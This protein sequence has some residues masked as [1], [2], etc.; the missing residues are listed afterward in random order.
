[1][2]LIDVL[3]YRMQKYGKNARCKTFHLFCL[4][5]LGSCAEIYDTCPLSLCS[6]V[7]WALQKHLLFAFVGMRHAMSAKK[8]YLRR[9]N[10]EY[11]YKQ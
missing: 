5:I 3:V 1:M 9:G 8:R 4:L 7:I 10:K 11:S 2:K 6:F